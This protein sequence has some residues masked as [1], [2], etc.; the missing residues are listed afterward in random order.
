MTMTRP[1]SR[2]STHRIAVAETSQGTTAYQ[3]VCTDLIRKNVRISCPDETHLLD[4][5]TKLWTAMIQAEIYL[6]NLTEIS[7]DDDISVYKPG[8]EKRDYIYQSNALYS[9][10]C[11]EDVIPQDFVFAQN[12]LKS[13]STI[14]DGFSSLK[15]MLSLVHPILNGRRPPY[16]PP[17]YSAVNNL[18]LYKQSLRNFYLF[19]SIYGRSE[20]TELDKSK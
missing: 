15:S 20:Y 9:F 12:Y 10:L 4:F 5:Y 6:R 11:N 8:L 19:Y 7:D 13:Q 18:H 17:L 14:M 1:V 2:R 16:H 3:G